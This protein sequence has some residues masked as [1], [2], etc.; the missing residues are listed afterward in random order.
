MKL[1]EQNRKYKGIPIAEI[2][3]DGRIL[4]VYED[5]YALA[6]SIHK[7]GK[8]AEPSTIAKRVRLR[9]PYLG[10]NFRF[11]CIGDFELTSNNLPDCE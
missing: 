3:N 11:Y 1:R 7:I 2:G 6:E 9:K 8:R 4:K 5:L 10:R